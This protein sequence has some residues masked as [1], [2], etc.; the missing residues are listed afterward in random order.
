MANVDR[1]NGFKPIGTLSGSDWNASV[2]AIQCDA[3]HAAIGVGDLIEM[4]ADGYPDILTAGA[5]DSGVFGLVVGIP[6]AGFGWNATTGKFGDNSLS[7]SEPTLVGNGTRVLAA[8]TEGTLMVATAPDLV[9]IAQE[10]GDTTPLTLTA[11]GENVDI[12]NA[13]A[14]SNSV[15]MIDSTTNATTATHPLRLLGL[16]NTPENELASVDA[17]KPWTKWKVTF[18]NHARSGLAVGV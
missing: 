11:V 1:A 4:T 17:A 2:E 8:N 5:I 9:M 15:M 6:P 3:T 12:V 7:A 16:H 13:G 18:A 10:D 14:V